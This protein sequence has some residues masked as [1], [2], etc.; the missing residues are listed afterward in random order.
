[1]AKYN[2]LLEF[3]QATT[4]DPKPVEVEA[5]SFQ[6]AADWVVFYDNPQ[7]THANEIVAAFPTARVVRILRE[8]A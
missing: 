1:M 8:D 4:G 6:V 5:K 2:V 7:T 3:E